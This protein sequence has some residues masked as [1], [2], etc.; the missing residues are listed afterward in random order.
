MFENSFH[1]YRSCS[2]CVPGLRYLSCFVF[3]C[4]KQ[5]E[6]P[7]CM[8]ELGHGEHMDR[9]RQVVLV[10]GAVDIHAESHHSYFHP[11]AHRT[12]ISP[13]VEDSHIDRIRPPSASSP[14]SGHSHFDDQ[15]MRQKKKTS[16]G[17]DSSSYW[18]HIPHWNQISDDSSLFHNQAVEWDLDVPENESRYLQGKL[19]PQIEVDFDLGFGL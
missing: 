16:V 14:F 5:A 11:Y 7:D 2:H 18:D 6:S 15:Y 12:H 19:P 17:V 4:G 13:G 8:L 1:D 10:R 3:G 9:G